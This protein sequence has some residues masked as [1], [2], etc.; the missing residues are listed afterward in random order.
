MIAEED[1]KQLV[2]IFWPFLVIDINCSGM[3]PKLL[4]AFLN[5]AIRSM[6]TRNRLI[7]V[8]DFFNQSQIIDFKKLTFLP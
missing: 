6:I 3:S 2:Q 5:E 4:K 8:S 1:N 7:F